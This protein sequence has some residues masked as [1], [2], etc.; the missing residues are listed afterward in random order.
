MKIYFSCSLTG[1]RN[2]EAMYGA[3]VDHLLSQGHDVL[4]AHL[5]R[6]EVMALEQVVVPREVLPAGPGVDPGMRRSGGG[7][8]Y[9]VTR[10]GVRDRLC[11]GARQAGA[12][13][14]RVATPGFPRC[15]RATTPRG[16]A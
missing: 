2:D 16:C 15:S 5:A 6:P 13:L 9:A 14:R 4:T 12:V 7:G 1:G 8:Q 11:P 3:I 10:C